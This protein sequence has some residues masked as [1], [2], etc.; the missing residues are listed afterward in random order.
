M[1][2]ASGG[3]PKGRMGGWLL[4][5]GRSLTRRLIW[6]AAGWIVAALVITGMV[7]TSQFRKAACGDWAVC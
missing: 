3:A 4:R 5:P 2:D 6:L 7:L 1:T